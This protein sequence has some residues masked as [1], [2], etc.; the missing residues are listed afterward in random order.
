MLHLF[1]LKPTHA[2]FCKIHSHSQFTTRQHIGRYTGHTYAYTIYSH[3]PDRRSKQA[4][5]VVIALAQRTTP[6]DGKIIMT[7]TCRVF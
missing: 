1:Y 6:E 7:E 4:E 3:V 5:K 2:L